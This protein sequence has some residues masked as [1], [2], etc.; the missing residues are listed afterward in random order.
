MYVHLVHTVSAEVRSECQIPGTGLT[1][2]WELP[3]GCWESKLG[4]PQEQQVLLTVEPSSLQ[5][6]VL[7]L[8]LGPHSRSNSNSCVWQ[9][10]CMLGTI[11]TMCVSYFVMLTV[12]LQGQNGY[13]PF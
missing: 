11:L 5:L 8:N 4:L 1:D 9:F 10:S 3:C 13:L 2:G 12:R 6:S 7:S